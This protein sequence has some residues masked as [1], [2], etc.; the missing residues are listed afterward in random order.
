MKKSENPVPDKVSKGNIYVPDRLSILNKTQPH[1]VLATD[2]DGQPYTSL[3]AFALTPD[4]KGVVFAT[5]KSTRKYKNILK[6]KYV[7]L[8]IDTR[9]N[10][11]T[12]YM[13]A[14]SVTII[15]NAQ[16]LRKSK[17]WLGMAKILINKH[18]KLTKFINSYNTALVLVEINKCIHVTRFQSIS[19][20]NVR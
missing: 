20:W 17:K 1:A 14:E 9:S 11:E 3:I 13:D 12:D 4:M 7:S 19:E 6:N 16:P 2:S 15:G 18:P 8:L 5:P 10:T